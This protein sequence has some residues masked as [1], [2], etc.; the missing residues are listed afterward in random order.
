MNIHKMLKDA[1]A[2]SKY[3]RTNTHVVPVDVAVKLAIKYADYKASCKAEYLLRRIQSE[4]GKVLK[5]EKPEY[6]KG[7]YRK[8][9]KLK[10]VP[11]VWLESKQTVGQQMG[12]FNQPEVG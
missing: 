4:M 7:K 2:H 9:M 6:R 8:R 10:K 5:V 3:I 12:F 11:E 1:S